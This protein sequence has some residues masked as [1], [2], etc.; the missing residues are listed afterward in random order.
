ME[1]GLVGLL[2]LVANIYAIYQTLASGASTAAKLI[3]TLVI[4]VLPVLGF[5]AWLIAGP[6]AP[7]VRA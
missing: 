3:W 7:A 2:I 1:Y 4:L 5:I 6:R